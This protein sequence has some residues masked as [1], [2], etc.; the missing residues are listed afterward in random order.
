M[1]NPGDMR[2]HV[3]KVLDKLVNQGTLTRDQAD[4]VLYFFKE[5]DKERK[6]DMEVMKDM[7]PED[8]EAYLHEKFNKRP[9]FIK[10]LQNAADLSDEQAKT[11]ADAI[12]PPHRPNP[13]GPEG[14]M[15][16]HP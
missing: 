11:V 10:E 8:R 1:P 14:P 16:P 13:N 2:Q 4:K 12:R 3:N 7:T 9:D 15:M 6:N 5:K